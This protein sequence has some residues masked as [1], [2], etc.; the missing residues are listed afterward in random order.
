M[1][2]KIP[3]LFNVRFAFV[4]AEFTQSSC[5]FALIDVPRQNMLLFTDK[6]NIAVY[7]LLMLALVANLNLLKGY[8]HECR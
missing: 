6:F 7:I 2:A 8:T 5:L 3:L 4:F 1:E